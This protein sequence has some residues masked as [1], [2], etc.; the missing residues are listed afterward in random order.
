MTTKVYRDFGALSNMSAPNNE[1][2]VKQYTQVYQATHKGEDRLPFMNR[3]FISFSYGERDTVIEET[4]NGTTV[5][6]IEKRPVYIEDFNLIATISG[7][8][9]ERDAYASFEDLTSVYDTI[10]GQFYWGT[11][12]HS[13][14]LN[15]NLSTDGMTQRQLDDFKF[16]FRA[17]QIKELILS[18]HPNRAALAR[19]AAPPRLKLLPFEQPVTVSLG[20]GGTVNSGETVINTDYLTST[21]L[22][23]GDIEL[24]LVLDEPFWYAKKNILGEQ[25]TLNGYYTNEWINANG[26]LE[27]VEGSRDALK[28]VYEDRIPLG[29]TT[30]I[31]VF[32]GGNV[33]ARILYRPYS[34]IAKVASEDDYNKNKDTP[35]YYNNGTNYLENGEWVSSDEETLEG[36]TEDTEIEIAGGSGTSAPDE[37]NNNTSS[38]ETEKIYRFSETNAYFYGAVIAENDSEEEKKKGSIGGAMME[39]G[40]AEGS[41]ANGVEL[42]DEDSPSDNVAHLYYAGTAPSPI[43][44]RFKLTPKIR[45]QANDGTAYMIE[46][47]RNKYTDSENYYNTIILTATQ[48]H[49]FMFT[50]PTIFASYN[51]VI[52]IFS[53][54]EI[55]SAGT[56]WVTVR[57]TIRD[58]IRHPIVRAWAN[59]LIDR[60]DRENGDGFLDDFVTVSES[61]IAL[62]ISSI[63]G[64]LK[65]GMTLLFRTNPQDALN[66]SDCDDVEFVFNGKTGTAT[67]TFTVRNPAAYNIPRIQQEH[68]DELATVINALGEQEEE[69][70][71]EKTLT[72]IE[73]VGD[74]VKSSYLIL[75]E[76]NILDENLQVQAWQELHPDYAYKIQHDVDD[77]LKELHFEFKNMYL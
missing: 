44:L 54:E 70:T 25:N 65:L 24:E 35:G 71:I 45:L 5:Q 59:K 37:G 41:E 76:R 72:L 17:G 10:H 12:F 26:Q 43:I 74:M 55:M 63:V 51:Q 13:N 56:A 60:F 29:S 11:Y 6:K 19:V 73:N 57:E 68:Q 15:F 28:I 53:N 40:D 27:N 36:P 16:W 61:G 18:E 7:D 69:E 8:R 62:P 1:F 52:K 21:T 47:P 32:L 49:K 66:Q 64:Q 22:Y 33:Y 34:L 31:S 75:D 3:S 50:I 2:D 20:V 39:H 38:N 30:A 67:G 4:E 77:R 23:K 58:T 42:L 46:S 48:E 14:T 9:W